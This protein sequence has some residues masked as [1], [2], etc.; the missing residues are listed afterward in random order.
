MA[1]LLTGGKG[2]DMQRPEDPEK[3]QSKRQ[4]RIAIHRE[5]RETRQRL[6]QIRHIED[7]TRHDLGEIEDGHQHKR[8]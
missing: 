7:I 1:A 2:D 6:R 4:H 5:R 3:R 8:D